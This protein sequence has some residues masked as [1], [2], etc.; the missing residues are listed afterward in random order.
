MNA[1]TN[2]KKN[3]SVKK[4]NHA[5][6][7]SNPKPRKGKD[8]VSVLNAKTT[9]T[10]TPAQRAA[11]AVA[12]AGVGPKTQVIRN[13]QGGATNIKIIPDPKR[14]DSKGPGPIGGTTLGGP[15][16][17]PIPD[18]TV[19]QLFYEAKNSKDLYSRYAGLDSS[20]NNKETAI[21]YMRR[22]LKFPIDIVDEKIV[23]WLEEKGIN[24]VRL[25]KNFK[26][27]M[28][29][30]HRAQ[31][32]RS[33]MNNIIFST[34]AEEAH[35]LFMT[36]SGH[37]TKILDIYGDD[38]TAH[39]F[40]LPPNAYRPW[41]VEAFAPIVVPKDLFKNM[42]DEF[43]QT[44]STYD[45]LLLKDVYIGPKELGQHMRR[46]Q[47]NKAHVLI[48]EHS[49]KHLMGGAFDRE[50][51]WT[52]SEG[53]LLQVSGKGEQVW[54][55]TTTKTDQWFTRQLVT[56]DPVYSLAWHVHRRLS[57]YAYIQVSLVRTELIGI[58]TKILKPPR[59]HE[60]ILEV[61]QLEDRDWVQDQ[62]QHGKNL[63]NGLFGEMFAPE[64]PRTRPVIVH[65]PSI[66][67]LSGL[68]TFRSRGAFQLTAA[69][70]QVD[71]LLQL[72]Q[73]A[74]VMFGYNVD[75][76]RTDTTQY[77]Q[78]KNITYEAE[79]AHLL[80]AAYAPQIDL[81]K[82]MSKAI[83]RQTESCINCSSVTIAALTTAVAIPTANIAYKAFKRAN[84]IDGAALWAHIKTLPDAFF[85]AEIR[86]LSFSMNFLTGTSLTTTLAYL[87]LHVL[88]AYLEEG[89]S[90]KWA[91]RALILETVV[92]TALGMM[93]IY[94]L[95]SIALFS[96]VVRPT[97]DSK[98]RK[99]VGHLA[100]NAAVLLPFPLACVAQVG[101]AISAKFF[102][103]P[104]PVLL[105]WSN[106][107]E[108]YHQ[109][110]V[111]PYYSYPEFVPE[112]PQPY[113]SNP[114]VFEQ[115]GTLVGPFD[116]IPHDHDFGDYVAFHPLLST[117]AIGVR[118]A[119]P[120]AAA[121]AYHQRVV[122]PC[123]VTPTCETEKGFCS[124]NDSKCP[125]GRQW[126]ETFKALE[127][128][129]LFDSS[130]EPSE[131]EKRIDWAHSFKQAMKKR[132]NLDGL[133]KF[134]NDDLTYKTEMFVK[135]DEMIFP[136]ANG[137]Y[138]PRLI[139]SV[140]PA[141]QA[142][143]GTEVNRVLDAQK[144]WWHQNEFVNPYNS[145][146]TFTLHIGSGM[147]ATDLDNW[148]NEAHLKTQTYRKSLHL[149]FAGDDSL[150]IV[151][152]EGDLSY[153]EFDASRFER[154]QNK[155]LHTY[156]YQVMHRFG[157]P[158]HVIQKAKKIMEQIPT[159]SLRACGTKEQ[160]PMPPQRSTGGADTT[161]GN[162]N[163]MIGATLAAI[164]DPDL[165]YKEPTSCLERFKLH[166]IDVTYAF[167]KHPT[168]VTFLKGWWQYT[169][170]KR[171]FAWVP[172]PSQLIKLGKIQKDPCTLYPKDSVQEAYSKV[173]C[174]FAKCLWGV[175]R[176]YPLLGSLLSRY[177]RLPKD[178]ES[179]IAAEREPHK[180]QVDRFKYL[181]QESATASICYR[182]DVGER[183]LHEALEIIENSPFP[184][185]MS[186]RVF[187]QLVAV[188]YA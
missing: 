128:V 126:K 177:E 147:N 185:V 75:Q 118:P 36:N 55:P 149:I 25:V 154:S 67:A 110:D 168:L 142:A 2:N 172:L 188:D 16:T 116:A 144:A 113:L 62:I 114:A 4:T 90:K 181:D 106:F 115:E 23:S 70:K 34:I 35:Q 78:W 50:A 164:G 96:L 81:L 76:I 21:T 140:D 133:E 130:L 33:V 42:A 162:T 51:H 11:P 69:C 73:E 18:P 179:V 180:I 155:H 153:A 88:S 91:D 119:G 56:I 99:V 60:G 175:D 152:C 54:T 186:H 49:T 171:D 148:F 163:V 141:V 178:C 80:A 138:K 165:F 100:W 156:Q 94:T 97:L 85:R 77:I 57:T 17:P 123:A 122:I 101:M 58:Q 145:E 82:N 45:V 89:E 131:K 125:I 121:S 184:G 124:W 95:I 27:K 3:T 64:H 22:K 72:D 129:G 84:K 170:A 79:N 102:L 139:K 87:P 14:V 158:L 174:S 65:S 187:N 38:N 29:T 30:H 43:E 93:S 19:H 136:K 150:V 111:Q 28:S 108:D 47:A 26:H 13:K 24:N 9:S 160:I 151:N 61:V 44:K 39:F 117:T 107:R 74:I 32:A 161:C 7:G 182:Y 10:T 66:A 159:M 41:L 112:K 176:S 59:T 127:S 146:W 103:K 31:A 15:V 92:L 37:I 173:A 143:M 105:N 63:I 98:T 157:C 169:T 134:K 166:G 109:N 40:E 8:G 71:R 132:R 52:W 68:A 183:E 120:Y 104:K 12:L 135:S 137:T 53:L 83:D 167:S 86:P 6:N 46:L 20:L 48:Q 5:K 1:N